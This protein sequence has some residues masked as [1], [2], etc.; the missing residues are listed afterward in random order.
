MFKTLVRHKPHF[1]NKRMN[2]M[3]MN[4]MNREKRRETASNRIEQAVVNV[5]H[6]A[7]MSGMKGKQ[8]PVSLIYFYYTWA[9]YPNFS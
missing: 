7:G 5:R 2:E 6:L 1:H 4:S 8:L 3:K 9:L